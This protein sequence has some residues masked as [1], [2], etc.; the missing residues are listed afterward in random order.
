MCVWE[1]FGRE[2]K[3]SIPKDI[4]VFEF[5]TNRYLPNHLIEDGYTVVNTSWKPLYV[6]NQ[7]KWE[8]RTIYDWNMW[9]W[10]NW[11]DK[12]PSFNPIQTE[13][14]PLVIGAQMCSWEQRDEIE[15]PSLRK[16]LPVFVERIWNTEAQVPFA[17]V[18]TRVD[19]LDNRLSIL[20]DDS[21]QDTLLHGY[22]FVKVIEEGR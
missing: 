20:I 12:A 7:K 18:S 22:N 6:V 1:G 8:P 2:G 15:I 10:D 13:I 9:R 17:E 16:R 11:F 14:S 21:R 4:I 3:V 19:L 5:E